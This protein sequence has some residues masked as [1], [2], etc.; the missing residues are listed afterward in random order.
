VR[1]ISAGEG[2]FQETAGAPSR[3]A[4]IPR[5]SNRIPGTNCQPSR[6]GRSLRL[7]G[8][9]SA[10]AEQFASSRKHQAPRRD[11]RDDGR[12]LR[13]APSGYCPP[14]PAQHRQRGRGREWDDCCEGLTRGFTIPA[15]PGSFSADACEAEP[16]S[17]RSAR[18]E[19]G[20]N[21]VTSQVRWPFR[22]N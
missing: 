7:Q 1:R 6:W 10:R 11:I 13:N 12:C 19:R 17:L 15:V 8:K 14:K 2:G 4:G 20:T 9:L 5:P 3:P 18:R 16:F 21:R 22:G